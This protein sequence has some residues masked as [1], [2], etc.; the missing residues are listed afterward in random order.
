MRTP[1]WSSPG[2]ASDNAE[3]NAATIATEASVARLETS[4]SNG[5]EIRNVDSSGSYAWHKSTDPSALGAVRVAGISDGRNSISKR[6]NK[7]YRVSKELWEPFVDWMQDMEWSTMGLG[8]CPHGSRR[9]QRRA[10]W[11]E[12]ALIF[13]IQS[14]IRLSS[15]ALNHGPRKSVQSYFT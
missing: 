8:E 15:F 12:I 11:V 5:W 14:G 6:K 10:N 1:S 3:M 4:Q 9:N 7:A 13:Q 2:E